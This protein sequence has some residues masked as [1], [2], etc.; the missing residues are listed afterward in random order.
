MEEDEMD[1]SCST[2]GKKGKLCT[3]ERKKLRKP[4]HRYFDDVKMDLQEIDWQ[5][6]DWNDLA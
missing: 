6:I 3:K 4:L 1:E 2:N 5:G